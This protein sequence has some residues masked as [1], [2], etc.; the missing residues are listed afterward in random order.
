MVIQLLCDHVTCKNIGYLIKFGEESTE[1]SAINAG[2]V[3]FTWSHNFNKFLTNRNYWWAKS[4]K[5]GPQV[6]PSLKFIKL[7][8][9]TRG[10]RCRDLP[11]W[12]PLLY[13][14][15][16]HVL[17]PLGNLFTKKSCI[18]QKLHQQCS[19]CSDY[20]NL[21]HSVTYLF[22]LLQHLLIYSLHIFNRK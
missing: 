21:F 14:K 9:V 20:E 7:C 16:I 19:F 15:S 5:F 13:F 18:G 6:Q 12:F 11:L 10:M 2:D 3:V 4:I 1:S 17:L 22:Y 8:R